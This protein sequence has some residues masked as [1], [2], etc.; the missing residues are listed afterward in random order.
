MNLCWGPVHIDCI[1]ESDSVHII[2]VN[3][4]IA[5]SFVTDII[6]DAW[7]FDMIDALLNKLNGSDVFLPERAEPAR[8]AQAILFLDSDSAYRRL[9]HHLLRDALRCH[10]PEGLAAPH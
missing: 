8:F 10:R 6:R 3:P 9:S 1:T 4:R 7:D 2:E 5:G